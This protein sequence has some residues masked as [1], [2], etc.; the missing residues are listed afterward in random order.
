MMCGSNDPINNTDCFY[1]EYGQWNPSQPLTENRFYS[2]FS[3]SPYPKVKSK[4]FVTGGGLNGT[5]SPISS[6]ELLT[7][8]GWESVAA[9]LPTPLQYHCMV[10]LNS[11]TA[12]VTG[13]I[14]N[15]TITSNTYLR[16]TEINQWIE[17]PSL[18]QNRYQ[19]SCGRIRNGKE[20]SKFEIIVVGGFNGSD[21]S[22]VEI[23]DAET[24][25]WRAGAS[26][27]FAITDAV[28][29]EDPTGGVILVGG[30]SKISEL[31][32]APLDTLFRLPH[33]D[34]DHWQEMP[35]KLKS[36]RRY[37]SAFLIPN[38]NVDCSFH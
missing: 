14:E 20:S 4:I 17:G 11:I 13:G 37:H 31:D 34:A 6:A 8:K 38:E 1:F 33:A 30:R 19:H 16:N 10:L 29:V 9:P 26:L 18:S 12:M 7:D 15:T 21:L 2:G 5:L 3:T 32:P 25:A 28:L 24:Y 36:G 23:F 22:S 35:Q 27:P